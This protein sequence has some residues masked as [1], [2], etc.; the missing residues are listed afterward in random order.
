MWKSLQFHENLKSYLIQKLVWIM[1]EVSEILNFQADLSL[2]L[3]SN[4][5]KKF[6]SFHN[7]FYGDRNNPGNF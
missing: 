4:L 7:I 1:Q 6:Y 2:S 3:S 5:L